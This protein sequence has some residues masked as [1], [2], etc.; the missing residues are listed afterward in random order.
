MAGL[1]SGRAG[2]LVGASVALALPAGGDFA[3]DDVSYAE[4]YAEEGHG[5]VGNEKPR[6]EPDEQCHDQR[7]GGEAEEHGKGAPLPVRRRRRGLRL[8]RGP[9]GASAGPTA[10]MAAAP[11]SPAW[12]L[13]GHRYARFL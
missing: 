1:A 8:R 9:A 3:C 2:D 12:S 10:S 4:G 6:D 13:F 5:E 11:P 7:S